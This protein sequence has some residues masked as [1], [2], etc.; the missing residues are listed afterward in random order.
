MRSTLLA[1]IM[2]LSSLATWGQAQGSQAVIGGGCPGTP[3]PKVSGPLTIGSV[4]EIRDVGCFFVTSPGSFHVLFFGIPLPQGSWMPVQLQQFTPVTCQ[5]V[6][7]PTL[8]VPAREEPVRLLIPPLPALRGVRVGL[9]N[10]CFVCG[11]RG[12]DEILSQGLELTIR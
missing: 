3:A 8:A 10:F 1:L 5:V 12:C 6:I 7:L 9:Q 11:F 4:M 2:T